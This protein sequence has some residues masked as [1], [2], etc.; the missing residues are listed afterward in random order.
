[1]YNSLKNNGFY[2][3]FLLL[4]LFGCFQFMPHSMPAESTVVVLLG[5]P[6]SGKGTQSTRVSQTLG[7]PHISTGDL[8]R[9]NVKNKTALGIKVQEYLNKGK[10]VPDSLV[11]DMLFD[12]LQQ[13]DCTQGFLL[14]GSPRTVDQAKSIRAYLK[15]IPH[16]LVVVA[17]DVPDSQVV[18]RITNRRICS[19]C[20]AIFHLE[21]KRPKKAESCDSCGS[22]LTQRSDDTVEVIQKRLKAYH[23][24]T[25]PVNDYYKSHKALHTVDGTL[26]PDSIFKK[27]LDSLL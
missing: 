3:R 21:T 9:N 19:R 2:M 1:M 27:I 26:D 15:N 25:K 14:D 11:L 8:F 6:G 16:R 4:L 5:P 10:L 20:G 18:E 24:E 22:P 17:L 7:I 12:R 13:P 23:E